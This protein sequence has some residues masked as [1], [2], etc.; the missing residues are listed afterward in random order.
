[1][2]TIYIL[3]HMGLLETL[4]FKISNNGNVGWSFD[5]VFDWGK[6]Q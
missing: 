2:N 6:R 4:S 3:R 1:M 5:V